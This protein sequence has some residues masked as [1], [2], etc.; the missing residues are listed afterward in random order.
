MATVTNSDWFLQM[1]VEFSSSNVWSFGNPNNPA[2]SV[3]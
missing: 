2:L 1:V 3:S